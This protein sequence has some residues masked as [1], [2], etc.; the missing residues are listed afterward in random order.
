M[1]T[2]LRRPGRCATSCPKRCCLGYELW[3]VLPNRSD[4]G[5]RRRPTTF[6]AAPTG[7]TIS[8]DP[9][10]TTIAISFLL[11]SRRGDTSLT[12]GSGFLS[13]WPDHAASKPQRCRRRGV[14]IHLEYVVDDATQLNRSIK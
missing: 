8:R 10:P 1:V 2:I 9:R 7:K 12:V 4:P 6:I 14:S 13:R 11:R 3:D 5:I